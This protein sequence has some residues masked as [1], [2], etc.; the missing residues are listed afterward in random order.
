MRYLYLLFN[1]ILKDYTDKYNAYATFLKYLYY[2]KNKTNNIRFF[3]QTV[4]SSPTFIFLSIL[5]SFSI[6]VYYQASFTPYFRGPLEPIIR[7][8]WQVQYKNPTLWWQWTPWLLLSPSRR[9]PPPPTSLYD[10]PSL[11]L[12]SV[13][14][15]CNGRREGMR[16]RMCIHIWR[17]L[18][19]YYARA[20][21]HAKQYSSVCHILDFV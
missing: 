20:L 3:A 1:N 7:R 11:P 12:R 8:F 16:V 5:L 18:C 17:S 10:C 4:V 9:L 19:Y 13:R 15:T 6:L 14:Y 21:W 2:M